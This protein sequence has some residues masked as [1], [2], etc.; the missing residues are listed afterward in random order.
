MYVCRRNKKD[1]CISGASLQEPASYVLRIIYIYTLESV[2]EFTL[3]RALLNVY[4]A[5]EISLLLCKIVSRMQKAGAFAHWNDL[6][7]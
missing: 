6:I 2:Y 4:K 5:Q 3:L 1:E 7:V